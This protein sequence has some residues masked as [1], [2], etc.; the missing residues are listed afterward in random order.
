MWEP[1]GALFTK[2]LVGTYYVPGTVRSNW[3]ACELGLF[4]RLQMRE[5]G[6]ERWSDLPQLTQE[7]SKGER[8]RPGSLAPGPRPDPLRAYCVHARPSHAWIQGLLEA[9]WIPASA[10]GTH[11]AFDHSH[12]GRCGPTH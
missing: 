10:C 5:E 11:V 3:Q 4:A 2:C 12:C 1:E 7:E 6:T 9:G 8:F